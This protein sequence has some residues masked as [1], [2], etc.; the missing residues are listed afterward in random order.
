MKTIKIVFLLLALLLT[1]NAY[2]QMAAAKRIP[3][4]VVVEAGLNAPIDEVWQFMNEKDNYKD[5]SGARTF[6]PQG[7]FAESPVK[8]VGHDG[9]ARQQNISYINET[10]HIISFFVTKSDYL[11]NMWGYTF[12]L[13]PKGD[14][15]CTLSMNV[16]YTD[17]TVPDN[18]KKNMQQEFTHMKKYMEKKFK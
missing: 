17:G 6:V 11:K 10:R 12:E 14:K 9:T 15:K 13:A 2:A 18:L 8:V 3:P 4:Q 16:F 1:G 7:M 5:M